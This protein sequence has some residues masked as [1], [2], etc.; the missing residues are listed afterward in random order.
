MGK[1]DDLRRLRATNGRFRAKVRGA[2]PT[3]TGA[4]ASLPVSL[5]PDGPDQSKATVASTVEVLGDKAREKLLSRRSGH[6]V[7]V[8]FRP[9]DLAVLDKLRG[10]LSRS[11]MFAIANPSLI[12]FCL[13]FSP[14]VFPH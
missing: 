11:G 6:L 2:G 10:P 1:M 8:W 7:Q 5:E 13:R 3:K 12:S 4:G 9:D 14:A